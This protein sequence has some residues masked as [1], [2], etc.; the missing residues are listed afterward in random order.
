VQACQS[1]RRDSPW[2]ASG[3]S[4]A[5][6][7]SEFN[8]L[9]RMV[10]VMVMMMTLNIIV[11]VIVI[12]MVVVMQRRC[13][14]TAAP[15]S[16]GCRPNGSSR[17]LRRREARPGKKV[18]SHTEVTE[19]KYSHCF[20]AILTNTNLNQYSNNP[21]PAYLRIT[22][23]ASRDSLPAAGGIWICRVPC[24]HVVE[25]VV[26]RHMSLSPGPHD[27]KHRVDRHDRNPR[28]RGRKVDEFSD[29]PC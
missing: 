28:L 17:A 23:Y 9:I 16:P 8:H 24:S 18:Q 1:Q 13:P 22:R 10:A 26:G 7:Y 5:Q 4:R 6:I 14:P 3:T 12:V 15:I 25:P 11:I 29:E 19:P 20:T 21:F 2:F 27:G